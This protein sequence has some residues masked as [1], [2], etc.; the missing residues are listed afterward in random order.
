MSVD[1]SIVCERCGEV[2]LFAEDSNT[3]KLVQFT[4]K[5]VCGNK[6]V[7]LFNG[8]PRLAGVDKYYF[9]FTDEYEVQCGYRHRS[10][11]K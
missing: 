7:K 4:A 5:C 8:Y 11:K 2:L 6:N 9:E 1:N 10:T 3:D